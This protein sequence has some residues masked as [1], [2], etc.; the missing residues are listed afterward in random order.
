MII[1]DTFDNSSFISIIRSKSYSDGLNKIIQLGFENNNYCFSIV[2]L[3]EKYNACDKEEVTLKINVTVK[4]YSKLM[5]Y[6]DNSILK[7]FKKG[8]NLGNSDVYFLKDVNIEEMYDIFKLFANDAEKLD[9]FAFSINTSI[10]KNMNL[11]TINTNPD[12]TNSNEGNSPLKDILIKYSKKLQFL[13]KK[14]NEK[15]MIKI[16]KL[17]GM[18]IYIIYIA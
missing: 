3:N 14:M 17:Y 5:S 13:N 4:E 1:F 10:T 9:E 2:T 8:Y 11:I 18:N 12:S 15:K 6:V 7:D 16:L